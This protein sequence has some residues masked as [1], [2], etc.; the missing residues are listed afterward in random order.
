MQNVFYISS[1]FIYRALC[2]FGIND[3]IMLI[4]ASWLHWI[5]LY[6]LLLIY[7]QILWELPLNDSSLLSDTSNNFIQPEDPTQ[8]TFIEPKHTKLQLHLYITPDLVGFTQACLN[9]VQ[10]NYHFAFPSF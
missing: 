5:Y 10:I 7:C 4:N 3:N 1:S 8:I 9:I 2:Y 6:L